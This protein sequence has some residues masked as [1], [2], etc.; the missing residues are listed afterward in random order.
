MIERNQ[1]R[2][3]EVCQKGACLLVKDQF[4][5]VIYTL[6]STKRAEHHSS[7]TSLGDKQ[8]PNAQMWATVSQSG[9]CVCD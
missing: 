2:M 6:S 7:A 1:S 8:D 9:T 3:E 5:G 4:N